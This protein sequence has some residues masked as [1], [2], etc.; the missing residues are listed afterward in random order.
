MSPERSLRACVLSALAAAAVLLAPAGAIAEPRQL[1]PLGSE[2]GYIVLAGEE[3]LAV[4]KSGRE[5]TIVRLPDGRVLGRFPLSETDS[6]GVRLDASPTTA[7]LV[8][9]DPSTGKG[10]GGSAQVFS[11]P[12]AGPLTALGPR[13]GWRP[14]RYLPLSV[15]VDGDRIFLDETRY[16]YSG[17]RYSVIEP[18]APPRPLRSPTSDA[19]FAG[20]LVA[21]RDVPPGTPADADVEAPLL[22]VRDWRA[23]VPRWTAT[24]RRQIE[25]FDL[26]P[27]GR[28][29]AALTGGQIVEVAPGGTAVRRVTSSGSRPRFAGDAIVYVRRASRPSGAEQLV[30][31]R[32]DGT[33][34]S[35][36]VRSSSIGSIEGDENRVVWQA[37]GCA[38]VAGIDEPAALAPGP[39][40]CP[41]SEVLVDEEPV[42][43]DPR[44][45]RIPFVLSCVSAPPPGCR[46]T[47]R[48]EDNFAGSG[49]RVS[50]AGR[51]AVPVGQRRKLSVRLS[52]RG[53][54]IARREGRVGFGADFY[55]DV[56]AVD[57][58]GRRSEARGLLTVDEG[59]R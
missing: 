23:N 49:G 47:V 28:A 6:F 12:P 10:R 36:G 35:F 48:L 1:G 22:V 3:V 57:P 54:R 32:P 30:V 52:R 29:V 15:Q 2:G 53:Y 37:N 13:R 44:T 7:A 9:P 20:D 59:R 58:A 14:G 51:F 21:F 19:L 43:S 33:R 42:R 24:V 17:S 45:R 40:P 16:G 31:A 41:R 26:R 56:I 25:S 39:G 11:G 55:V 5:E 27:D 46:G 34:R 8:A 38:L 50:A 4:R 18:G